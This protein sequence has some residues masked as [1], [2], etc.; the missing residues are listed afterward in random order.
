MEN[1]AINKQ[2]ASVPGER[3]R[4]AF[5]AGTL[6]K[7]GAEKQLFYM[8]QAL[9]LAGVDVRVFHLARGGFYES[10]LK[11]M[12]CPS[13]WV[14]RR[15]NPLARIG[16]FIDALKTF[17]P[18]IIQASHFYTAVYA[19]AAS[20]RYRAMSIGSIRSD[21]MYELRGNRLFGPYLLR[22][23][24]AI[25]ANSYCGMEN[26]VKEGYDRAKFSVLL[27]VIDLAYFDTLLAKVPSRTNTSEDI[28]AIVVASL[29]PKKRIDIFLE[30]LVEVRK[31]MPS[32]KGMIVGT[33]PERA[34]LESLAQSLGLLP[35][36]VSFAGLRDDVPSLLRQAD[37]LVL[38]SEHE[39]F[40]N[41]ILEAMA[42]NLPI[43]TTPAGDAAR[44]VESCKAGF[45]VPFNDSA[46]MA[47]RI[48]ELARSRDRRHLFGSA[49]RRCVEEQYGVDGL[50]RR[51]LSIYRA[52]ASRLG[53]HRLLGLLAQYDSSKERIAELT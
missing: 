13:E 12:G 34:R 14:G 17:R 29:Y 9:R 32:V 27:N 31:R 41:V 36:G 33:G 42:S 35:D 49:G 22:T 50:G 48:V 30:A 26:I 23:P 44:I 15:S 10:V 18:H 21:G 24:A 1:S 11:D 53:K 43:V 45:V 46:K 51:L 47:E 16:S 6:G 28:L 38:P 37:M 8:V 4:V 39:G 52:S 20:W 25:I 40:P 19:V 2:T 5:I 7:G 3:L